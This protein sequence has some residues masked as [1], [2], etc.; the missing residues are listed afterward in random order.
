MQ[1]SGGAAD[2]TIAVPGLTVFNS[3]KDFP[4][5]RITVKKDGNIWES[6]TPTLKL[7]SSSESLE[8]ELSGTCTNGVYTFTNTTAISSFYVWDTAADC[9]TGKS[10]SVVE[11]PSQ[12]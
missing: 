6:G 11:A 1:G 9:Y 10:V 3:V 12:R 5:Y 4:T 2:F 7:S 8:N